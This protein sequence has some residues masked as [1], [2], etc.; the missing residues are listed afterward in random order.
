MRLL[1][2]TCLLSE[3]QKPDGSPAVKCF[4][5]N[6]PV[7]SLFMSVITLGEIAKGVAL[8]A[9]GRKKQGLVE[10]LGGLS[11]MFGDRTLPVDQESAEIWGELSAA[12]QKMGVTIPVADGLI[13]ATALRHGL[14]V[15]TR[16]TSHFE[17]A[18]AMV[19]NPWFTPAVSV[20]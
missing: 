20:Q 7:E 15:A 9:D 1:L 10:W 3:L 14:H 2:D 18:G 6:Q 4:I 5:A 19:I 13:A 11:G 12:G 17:S 16:N 8:M